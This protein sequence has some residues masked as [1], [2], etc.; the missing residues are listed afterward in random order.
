[1]MMLDDDDDYD[2]DDGGGGYDI[3]KMVMIMVMILLMIVVIVDTKL[4]DQSSNFIHHIPFLLHRY[5]IIFND[6][7][8][9]DKWQRRESKII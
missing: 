5:S 3:M 2:D 4:F 6:I 9:P 7:T 1:M 8:I